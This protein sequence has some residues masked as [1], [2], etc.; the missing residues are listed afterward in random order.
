[1]ELPDSIPEQL[2]LDFVEKDLKNA[3][4]FWDVE[5]G[6]R[7]LL[8][9][10]Q[11]AQ[12]EWL[13]VAFDI[14][15]TVDIQRGPKGKLDFLSLDN[16]FAN[17][18]PE[19]IEFWAATVNKVSQAVIRARLHHILFLSRHGNPGQHARE[20]AA[21]YLELGNGN[22][23]GVH[24]VRCLEW[25]F[26][27]YKSV[28]ESVGVQSVVQA[29]L[30]L[31]LEA[32]QDEAPLPGVSLAALELVALEIPSDPTL[33]ELIVKAREKYQD[34]RLTAD[35]IRIQKV[36]HK[37]DLAKIEELN[38][39]M[40]ESFLLE[41]DQ[42][43]GFLRMKFLEAGAQLAEKYGLSDLHDEAIRRMQ[44]ID[45]ESLG[46]VKLQSEVVIEGEA[47]DAARRQIDARVAFLIDVRSM[48]DAFKILIA[49]R[50]PSG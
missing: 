30:A 8:L 34:S 21:A 44:A 13:G 1:M 31:A 16:S 14:Q 9:Q 12:V 48:V 32:L 11:N 15:I 19:V 26:H 42:S 4:N 17:I 43:D 39:E 3:Q 7:S 20:A 29:L 41:A 49:S 5:R 24:R 27:L 28:S 25:S 35:T 40:V 6:L 22:W 10:T 46:M 38:R 2:V 18:E 23:I 36:I 33:A 45:F 50:P 37:G 47:L